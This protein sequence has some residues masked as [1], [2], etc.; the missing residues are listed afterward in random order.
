[1]S[2]RSSYGIPKKVGELGFDRSGADIVA[3]VD[4][5]LEGVV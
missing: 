3:V 4:D 1:M 2:W 5:K